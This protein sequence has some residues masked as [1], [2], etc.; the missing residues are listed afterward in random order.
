MAKF[1][2]TVRKCNGNTVTAYVQAKN[3]KDAVKRHVNHGETCVA[4]EIAEKRG[5]RKYKPMSVA[6]IKAEIEYAIQMA[7]EE[8]KNE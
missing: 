7:E 6:T 5:D 3:E 8:F 2:I 4:C 1:R